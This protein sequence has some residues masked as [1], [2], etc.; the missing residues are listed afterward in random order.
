MERERGRARVT[1]LCDRASA[2]VTDQSQLAL[3]QCYTLW[4]VSSTNK[5]SEL[6]EGTYIWTWPMR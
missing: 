5:Q 2:D 4:I 6:V 3:I 1:F